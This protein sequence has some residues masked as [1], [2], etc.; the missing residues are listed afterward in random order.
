[1]KSRLMVMMFLQFF[2]WGAWYATGGNYMREP[3]DDGRHLPGVHGEPDRIDRR[4][5]LPRDDRGPVLSR[6]RRCSGVMHML[7]GHLRFSRAVR[8]GGIVRLDAAV[9]RAPARCTC[10]A[11]CR[12]SGL[13]TATAFHLLQNKEREFPLVRVLR[14]HRVDRRRASSSAAPAGRHHRAADVH[15][16]RRRDA[17][18]PVQPSRCRTCRLPAPAR[19]SRSATSSASTRSRSSSSRPF[20][21]FILRRD[22]HQHSAGHVFRVRAGVPARRGHLR[23]R[24][25][26]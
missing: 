24:P 6:C 4:A 16:R 17:D 25:S 3:R 13:A 18:G 2:I 21:I 1:M 12:R 20:I 22:A 15:L 9:P 23:I 26:G 19:S 11:T 8:G 5:I 7:S 14:H 10:C